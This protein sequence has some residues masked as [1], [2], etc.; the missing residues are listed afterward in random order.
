MSDVLRPEDFPG[1]GAY[2][3]ALARQERERELDRQV[4]APG[5][6]G[7]DARR[8]FEAAIPTYLQRVPGVVVQ[9]PET[10]ETTS[11]PPPRDGQDRGTDGGGEDDGTDDGGGET[12]AEQEDARTFIAAMLGEFGL[13]DL[14]EFVYQGMISKKFD[15]DQPAAIFFA[16]RETDAYKKRFPANERRKAN[17]LPELDPSAYVNIEREY[18]QTLRTMGLPIDFVDYTNLIAGDV[19][20]AELKDRIEDGYRAVAEADPET[21]NALERLYGVSESGMAA[22]FLDPVRGLTELKRQAEAAKVAGAGFTGLG[23]TLGKAEAENVLAMGYTPATAR[24]RFAEQGALRGLYQEEGGE[25]ALT[26][27]EKVGA[28]IGYDPLAAQK[29][30]RRKQLRRAQFLGGG[31]FA[32]TTGATSG[33]TES[34]V[35]I[36]Q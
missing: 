8:E 11:V 30:E 2:R 21:K 27:A 9:D 22:Y 4:S 26:T 33:T 25:E 29:L 5:P 3:A 16:L 15:L 19:S 32:G 36:A 20:N 24:A 34:S 23:I 12:P 13:G 10:E 7:S 31:R 1:E 35:G 6:L 18:R 28:A 14:A 17:N